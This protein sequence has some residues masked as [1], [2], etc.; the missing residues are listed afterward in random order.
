MNKIYYITH[1]IGRAKYIVNFHDGVKTHRD[2]SP[3]YDIRICK[4]RRELVEFI[5]QLE[6]DHYHER[7]STP[8]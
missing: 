7:H 5:Q 6:E 2:G 4:T 1:N 3:F 8:Q